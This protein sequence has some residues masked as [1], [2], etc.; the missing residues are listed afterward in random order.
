MA[1]DE[2]DAEA[3]SESMENTQQPSTSKQTA[4][5]SADDPN[6]GMQFQLPDEI[7]EASADDG[8]ANL[9]LDSDD[10]N[11]RA[12]TTETAED[13]TTTIVQP[14]PTAATRK[15]TKRK[16]AA[17]KKKLSATTTTTAADTDTPPRKSKRIHELEKETA[18][19]GH[20]HAPGV[21]GSAAAAAPD[22][23]YPTD[24]IAYY[25]T[26]VNGIWTTRYIGSSVL[27]YPA[28]NCHLAGKYI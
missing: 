14:P 16:S 19:T 21:P 2:G 5:T 23:E 9:D 18:A 26:Q 28:E 1:I 13:D 24:F 25:R 17:S 15:S 22:N 6:S 20:G 7:D 12:T 11:T 3:V 8:N 27:S 4:S 10:E